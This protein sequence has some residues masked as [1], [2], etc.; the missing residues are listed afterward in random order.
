LDLTTEVSVT[1]GVDDVQRDSV[2]TR[3]VANR[4]VFGE[5]GDALFALEIHGVHD[6]LGDVL[7]FPE[8]TGLPQHG[9]DQR[10]LPVVDMGDDG[11]VA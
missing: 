8:C 7:A 10:G 3:P 4:H 2:I 1:G 9:V 11:E 6:A 5:D